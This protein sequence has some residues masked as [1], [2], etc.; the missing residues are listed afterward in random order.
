MTA[1]ISSADVLTVEDGGNQV[2]FER[3]WT[4]AGLYVRVRTTDPWNSTV[5]ATIQPEDVSFVTAW[6]NRDG[7]QPWPGPRLVTD[8]EEGA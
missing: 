1:T 8:Q 4:G 5:I 6:F 2:K 3:E 7:T